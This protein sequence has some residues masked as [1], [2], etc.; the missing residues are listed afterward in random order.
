MSL[1]LQLGRTAK[2][3]SLDPHPHPPSPFRW[4]WGSQCAVWALVMR[5]ANAFGVASLPQTLVQG[6]G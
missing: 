2:A 1:A 3:S 4:H 6:T 5:A